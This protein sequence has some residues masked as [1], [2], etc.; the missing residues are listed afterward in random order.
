MA[1]SLHYRGACATRPRYLANGR[2]TG[3]PARSAT[4]QHSA[5]Q[6]AANA[7]VRNAQPC[8][9][10]PTA[11]SAVPCSQMPQIPALSHGRTCKAGLT[12]ALRLLPLL[13]G[14]AKAQAEKGRKEKPTLGSFS[15]WVSPLSFSLLK[16]CTGS[17]QCT[18]GA[19]HRARLSPHVGATT[20]PS[21]LGMQPRLRQVSLSLLSFLWCCLLTA[22]SVTEQ[23]SGA[24]QQP[25]QAPS[26]PG[27]RSELCPLLRA[28]PIT[29]PSL[30]PAPVHPAG[31]EEPVGWC[32]VLLLPSARPHS[33]FCC[34]LNRQKRR[35]KINKYINKPLGLGGFSWLAATEGNDRPHGAAPGLNQHRAG[36]GRLEFHFFALFLSHIKTL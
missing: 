16:R 5:A 4:A 11:P 24:G 13:A 29:H 23:C 25:P 35:S 12:G 2:T 19:P 32:C 18:R 7:A 8:C 9:C 17:S 6:H 26:S 33:P 27:C 14:T 34:H 31:P 20:E 1:P 3:G 10:C 22:A 30:L 36:L 21:L 15:C 28:V